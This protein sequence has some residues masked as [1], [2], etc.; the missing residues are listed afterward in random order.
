MIDELGA[1][2]LTEG[3]KLRDYRLFHAARA[4]LLRRL[5]RNAEAAAAYREA[6]RLVS[7][8]VERNYLSRRLAEVGG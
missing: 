3:G 7:N 5:S 1:R 8:D 2:D 4:D 6:L